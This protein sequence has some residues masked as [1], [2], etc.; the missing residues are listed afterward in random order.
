[1]SYENFAYYY[2]S[3]MDQSFYDDYYQFICQNA[4]FQEVL[5]LGCGTG[6]MAIRLAKD[7]KI[8]TAT[9][10]SSDMLEVTKQKAMYEDVSLFLQKVDMSDFSSSHQVDLILCLCDSL[11]YLLEEKQIKQTFH[12]VYHSLK[13]GGTFIFDSNSLYKMNVILKDYQEDQEDEEFSF[14]WHVQHLDNGYVHHSLYIEDKIE[15]EIV[16]EEHY[17]KAYSVH[18]YLHWLQD[19]GFSNI[20]YYSDFHDYQEECERVVFVCHKEEHL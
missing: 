8:V 13:T 11:N 16:E 5:E 6:E 4:S 14:H 19:V 3:L 15:N 1:M 18:T 2:D 12:N 17:Q 20:Q 7:D 9:D 10:L